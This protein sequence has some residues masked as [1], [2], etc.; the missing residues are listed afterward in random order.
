[1]DAERAA[2]APPSHLR[3]PVAQRNVSIM[4]RMPAMNTSK[5]SSPPKA[6]RRMFAK[7][8]ATAPLIPLLPANA[9]EISSLVT[10][11]RDLPK[12]FAIMRP[13][14]WNEFSGL[15]D[16]YDIKWQDVIQPLEFITV[17]TSPVNRDKALKSI[18]SV[19]DVGEKLAKSRGGKLL[20]AI[21]KDIDGVPA[22]VFEIRKDAAHQLTLL[23]INKQKL[24]SVNA[25]SSEKRWSK[26]EKLLRGVVDSFKPKL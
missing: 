20:K 26:R 14:G 6:S 8:L 2:F 21:E 19:Q 17:L 25:S 16:N 23:S 12:G 7:L 1:M 18:G 15:E 11:Y 5:L 22:Y 13:N 24:Y 10:P 4:R 9:A 3:L